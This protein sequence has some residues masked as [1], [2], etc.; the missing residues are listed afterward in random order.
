MFSHILLYSFP[1]SVLS[2]QQHTASPAW[3]E[4][5]S[6]SSCGKMGRKKVAICSRDSKQ[7]YEWLIDFLENR[8]CKKTR[9]EARP[10]YIT[11]N[12]STF[13]QEVSGYNFAILYHTKKRG[14]INITNVP[15][16]L[17]DDELQFLH[18]MFGKQNVVVVIDD[19]EKSNDNEKRRIIEAQ[20]D[21]SDY[22][23]DVFLFTQEDKN[24]TEKPL[25]KIE[26]E[27]M[28]KNLKI[29]KK[30]IKKARWTKN[31]YAICK[32]PP[33]SNF[34]FYA[35]TDVPGF[36]TLSSMLFLRN[37]PFFRTLQ[38]MSESPKDHGDVEKNTQSLLIPCN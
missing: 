36:F 24:H 5:R 29:L 25:K 32:R 11:N 9:I 1:P 2:L 23:R 26:N 37:F 3:Y 31:K 6:P 13:H 30:C 18:D 34:G 8:M 22:A 10:V 28:Q 17:Y 19:L 21:L 16:S 4:K 12:I 35:S 27:K 38:T 33:T 7:N 15:S 20:R 14:R